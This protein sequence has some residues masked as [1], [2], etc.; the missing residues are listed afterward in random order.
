MSANPL[1]SQFDELSNAAPAAPCYDIFVRKSLWADERRIREK[2]LL[3]QLIPADKLD[4]LLTA[5]RQS[6]RI[7]VGSAVEREKAYKSKQGFEA[8]GLEVDLVPVLS[9]QEKVDPTVDPREECPACGEKVLLTPERQCPACTVFVD[10]VTDEQRLRRKIMNQERDR[11]RQLKARE[12]EN[13]E[14][15]Q[16]E[17]FEAEL[18]KKIREEI[19]EGVRSLKPSC[20]RRFAKKSKKKWG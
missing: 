12:A 3:D 7:K 13:S 17:K 20:A 10:K 2:A 9:L 6:P 15:R 11:V 1:I 5:L 4:K 19:E 8:A 18:R 16:R 14:K